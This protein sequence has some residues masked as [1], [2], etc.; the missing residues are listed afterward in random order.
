MEIT[1][2]RQTEC[3][4]V[5]SKTTSTIVITGF[6]LFWINFTNPSLPKMTISDKNMRRF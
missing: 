4:A 3:V 5:S 6:S 2:D 1:L